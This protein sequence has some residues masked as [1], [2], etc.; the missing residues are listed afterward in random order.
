MPRQFT[1]SDRFAAKLKES[2][3]RSTVSARVGANLGYN[4]NI[5]FSQVKISPY[6]IMNYQQQ[7][8][9][10]EPDGYWIMDDTNA[11]ME[12][13]SGN[14]Y[15]GTHFNTPTPVDGS[16]H[17]ET[18]TALQYNGTT[19]YSTVP[20]PS[21]T[22]VCTIE[23][24]TYWTSGTQSILRDSTSGSSGWIFAY[25]AGGF[26]AFRIGGTDYVTTVPT[27]SIQNA[28]KHLVLVK[29]GSSVEFFVNGTS[30]YTGSGAPSTAASMPWYFAKDGTDSNYVATRGQHLSMYARALPDDE[31]LTHYN[32]YAGV[33]VIQ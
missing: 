29:N 23:A 30:V 31:V 7:V 26:L 21:F 18:R 16:A 4:T 9:I 22:T 25:D 24:V 5:P 3:S 15:H 17:L 19:Q 10:S 32:A 2:P 8:M 27:A 33:E 14:A 6:S 20:N 1:L 28:W 13:D 11:T 12:D